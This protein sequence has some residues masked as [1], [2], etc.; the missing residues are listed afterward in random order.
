[1]LTA[2]QQEILKSLRSG[3]RYEHDKNLQTLIEAGL[4]EE[5]DGIWRL[6]DTGLKEA[7]VAEGF[8]AAIADAFLP[9]S[10]SGSAR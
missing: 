7:K 10:G 3:R 4:V 6:T 1:M 9:G 5:K 8:G 2:K